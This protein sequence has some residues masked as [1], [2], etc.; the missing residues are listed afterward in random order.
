MFAFSSERVDKIKVSVDEASWIFQLRVV[1]DV[2]IQDG[3]CGPLDQLPAG[4]TRLV[5]RKKK[6]S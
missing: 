5:K 6:A 2:F 4:A 1:A 3:E